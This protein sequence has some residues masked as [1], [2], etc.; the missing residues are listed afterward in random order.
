MRWIGNWFDVIPLRWL[1]VV[2]A[3]LLV[4]AA[5]FVAFLLPPATRELDESRKTLLESRIRRGFKMLVHTCVLL[6]LVSG[7]YN[8]IGN[9]D[10]YHRTLPL[11]HALLGLHV[12]VALAVFT[13]LLLVLA[14]RDTPRG[15]FTWIRITV[16]LLLLA[17]LMASA[18]KWVREH[19]HERIQQTTS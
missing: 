10:A 5:F 18:L 13:I 12:L 6:L 4:G 16:A 11:S 7:T 8:L 15:Y 1:H 2:S 14:R 19:P 9:R 3:C 17:V